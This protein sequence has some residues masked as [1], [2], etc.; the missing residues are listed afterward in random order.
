MHDPVFWASEGYRERVYLEQILFLLELWKSH[1][2]E[3]LFAYL[4]DSNLEIEGFFPRIAR[5]RHGYT[6]ALNKQI[7]QQ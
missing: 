7:S 4:R 3:I 5:Q 1:Q 2:F 6:K